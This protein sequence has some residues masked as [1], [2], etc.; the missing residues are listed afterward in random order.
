MG[1][2]AIGR[3]V[4]VVLVL[5]VL[6]AGE[7]EAVERAADVLALR[8][9]DAGGHEATVGDVLGDRP[10]V[11]SAWATYCAPCRAEAP[12][13]A[14]AAHRWRGARV[15]A[16][17]TDVGEGRE[18]ARVRDDWQIEV[19]LRGVASGQAAELDALLPAG[20]PATFFVRDG[21]VTRV[22]RFLSEEELARL[23]DEHLGICTAPRPADER[24][25]L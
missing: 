11:V 23:I 22:D 1:R 13:L 18:L 2:P 25:G 20:L 17:M 10:A 16:V 12:A 5:A 15:V 24:G 8:L 4:R 3:R 9:V 6:L 21:G 7:A 14:R 19:E